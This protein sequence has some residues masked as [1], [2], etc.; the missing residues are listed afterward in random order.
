MDTGVW[1]FAALFA[2]SALGGTYLSGNEW[3]RFFSSFGSWG[4]I[5]LLLSTICL[6]WSC[7]RALKISAENGIASLGDFFS[8]LLGQK[9][10]PTVTVLVY[11]IILAYA[12]GM[13]GDH[14]AEL[15]GGGPL[16]PAALLFLCAASFWLIKRGIREITTAAAI[17]LALGF[18]LLGLLYF[19]QRHIP[20]PSFTYQFNAKWFLYAFF[21]TS[22]HF[23][24]TLTILLPAAA[25]V[26]KISSLRIGL[27]LGS[28]MFLATTLLGHL[29]I[30]AYWHD[31][32][33]SAQP[34]QQVIYNL[35]PGSKLVYALVS[36]GQLVVSVAF[37][38]YGLT[39]PL[40]ERFELRQSPLLLLFFSLALIHSIVPM[41]SEWYSLFIYT[42][43]TYAGMALLLQFV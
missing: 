2:A 39:A 22:F 3:L 13:I 30:L 5:G 32:N 17:I 14:A 23:L 28:V 24:F 34:L 36:S 6:T 33:A 15:A 41:A 29:A 27:S 11:F 4:T 9:I 19:E 37:W 21:Y 38:F 20:M 42:S 26:K 8:F 1:R 10:A 43:A 12:G 7:Y 40:A 16:L 18:L 25:Q 31:V 35:S